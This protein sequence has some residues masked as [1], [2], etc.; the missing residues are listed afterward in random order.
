MTCIEMLH[1]CGLAY[2]FSYLPKKP[3]M[4]I[5]DITWTAVMGRGAMEPG[6]LRD[7]F[8]HLFSKVRLCSANL[9]DAHNID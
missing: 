6:L 4:E 9:F 7:I 3:I 2:V 1:K 5:E 8:K